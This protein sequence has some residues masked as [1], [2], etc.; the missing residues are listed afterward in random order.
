MKRNLRGLAPLILFV[1]LCT[2]AIILISMKL[3]KKYRLCTGEIV[4]DAPSEFKA[5]KTYDREIVF[6]TGID[7]CKLTVSADP[8]LHCTLEAECGTM[9]SEQLADGCSVKSEGYGKTA[10]TDSYNLR[11]VKKTSSGNVVMLTDVLLF[12]D[13]FCVKVTS[14][15]PE[16]S[17]NLLQDKLD[18]VYSTL[19]YKGP[20]ARDTT[21]TFKGRYF[22]ADI[23][24]LFS[25]CKA[26][27]SELKARGIDFEDSL[28]VR[29]SLVNY[30]PSSFAIMK[31]CSTKDITAIEYNTALFDKIRDD[32]GTA[33]VMSDSG[34][35]GKYTAFRV[36]YK[37]KEGE[38][39]IYDTYSFDDG[40]VCYIVS[41]AIPD[42]EDVSK[43]FFADTEEILDSLR[44]T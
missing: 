7:G 13:G 16:T 37:L 27:A 35:I 8:D 42:N 38:A 39:N 36:H 4:F 11:V 20:P 29:Y 23:P 12:G 22:E 21:E 26:D 14:E 6:D 2:A 30:K 32:S 19:A 25:Y 41:Y 9:S 34:K 44:A 1:V 33:V 10:G 17:C 5:E 18:K 43:S 31:V 15:V 3:D 40:G 24:P 28:Q